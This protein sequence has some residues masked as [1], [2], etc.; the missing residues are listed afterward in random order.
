MSD[1][2]PAANFLEKLLGLFGMNDPDAEKKRIVKAIGKDL[3][4][5]RYRFYKPKTQEAQPGLAKFFY[6]T[7]KIVAPAQVLL[8]N[9]SQSGV[10]RSFVIESFLTKEQRAISER[11]TESYIQG[12]A[13]TMSVKQLQ[14]ILKQDMI[15]FFSVFDAEKSTQIDNS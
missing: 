15:S 10:L 8:S 7:Y 12:K 5:S 14:E 9:A 13:A 6:E 11:L 2:A 1:D 3:S 4:R